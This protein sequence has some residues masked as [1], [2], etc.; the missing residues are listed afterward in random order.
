M[1]RAH[2]AVAYDAWFREQVRASIDDQRP[3]LSD[4]DVRARFAARKAALLQRVL[5]VT[6]SDDNR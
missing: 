3:S 1:T 4:E 2:E 6:L 5:D